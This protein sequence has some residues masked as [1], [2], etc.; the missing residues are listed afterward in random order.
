M[1]ESRLAPGVRFAI[2]VLIVLGAVTEAVLIRQRLRVDAANAKTEELNR[3]A[4]RYVELRAKDRVVA[5]A[6]AT[7][8]VAGPDAGAH[9]VAL[10]Q[11]PAAVAMP[12]QLVAGM[13]CE[14]VTALLGEPRTKG[15]ATEGK[16][17]LALWGYANGQDVWF[18]NGKVETWKGHPAAVPLVPPPKPTLLR[19]EGHWAI[20]PLVVDDLA[21]GIRGTLIGGVPLLD[22]YGDRWIPKTDRLQILVSIENRSATRK[23]D[24]ETWG[25]EPVDVG[26]ARA[27]LRD[28]LDN[29][30]KAIYFSLSEPALRTK[31]ASIYPGKSL[32]D[33]LV[34]ELPVTRATE[35]T[36][37]LPLENVEREGR[38]EF[39]LPVSS[40][41]HAEVEE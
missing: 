19:A 31:Q 39:I 34:F 25:A 15:A 10:A 27:G 20:A 11:P 13:N 8:K 41:P 17:Q 21:V 2:V 22:S 1:T 40:I 38:L 18:R 26:P 37:S 6:R 30:Y 29:S 23:A 12:P 32:Q 16:D 24:Y 33:V 5:R 28:D 9:P 3:L 36:L 7:A 14:E 4:K 35:L